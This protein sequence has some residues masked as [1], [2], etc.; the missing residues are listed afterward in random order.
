MYADRHVHIL[1]HAHMHVC[2]KVRM[3]AYMPAFSRVMFMVLPFSWEVLP[4]QVQR[5]MSTQH[6]CAEGGLKRTSMNTCP[7]HIWSSRGTCS[8]HRNERI[9]AVTLCPLQMDRSRGTCRT[10]HAD[11]PTCVPLCVTHLL[12][13][14]CCR[15]QS[16]CVMQPTS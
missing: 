12:P 15:S 2:T 13:A 7:S 14:D 11:F 8:T 5:P 1:T 3:H 16:D 4:L 6:F 9:Y 10:G